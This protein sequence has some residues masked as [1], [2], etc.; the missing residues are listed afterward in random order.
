MVDSPYILLQSEPT[1]S[2][3]AITGLTLGNAPAALLESS[4][5]CFCPGPCKP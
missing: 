4:L 2:G 5:T 1:A 3:K